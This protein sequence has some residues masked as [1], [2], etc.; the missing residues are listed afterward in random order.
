M[1]CVQETK[2]KSSK[3]DTSKM[4]LNFFTMEQIKDKSSWHHSDGT[5]II[6]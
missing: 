6:Q 2:W 5:K 1:L 3:V 4:S